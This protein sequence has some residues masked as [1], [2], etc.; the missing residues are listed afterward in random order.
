MRDHGPHR[1]RDPGQQPRLSV[2]IHQS[3]ALGVRMNE[4]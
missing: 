1:R 4:A 3:S 2:D